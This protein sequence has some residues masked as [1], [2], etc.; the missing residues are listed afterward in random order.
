M[1]D[2]QFVEQAN[3]EY[4]QLTQARVPLEDAAEAFASKDSSG[5]IPIVLVPKYTNRIRNDVVVTAV[6]ILIGGITIGYLLDNAVIISLAVFLG[7]VTALLGA[8]RSFI[9]RVPEGV[10]GLLAKG[11]RYYKTIGAGT[12]FIPP[13]IP[14]SHLVTRRE[15]PFDIPVV[16][17]PTEDNVR[18]NLDILLTF[19]ISDPY[20]FVFSISADDFDQ[21]F[22][23][24][25]QD[26]LRKMLRKIRSDEITDVGHEHMVA[27]REELAEE[28]TP[29]GIEITK[30][31]ITYAQPPPEFIQLKESLKLVKLK[32]EEQ[33][34]KQILALRQQQ[35]AEVLAQQKVVA[36]VQRRRE[37]LKALSQQSEA[38][39]EVVRLEAEAEE[40][41]L[42]KLDDRLEKY[43]RAAQYELELKRL[44]I[45]SS[46][47]G[48]TRAML[49]V[50]SAD[51]IARAFMLKD[52]MGDA[53]AV[54]PPSGA[55]IAD[56]APASDTSDS[57]TADSDTDPVKTQKVSSK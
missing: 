19:R 30:I 20:N 52:I 45:A 10:N 33:K 51:D 15:I 54:A 2:E 57:A 11:G 44:D 8:Y 5:R 49:Q 21:V 32:Q 7:I 38:R 50:G 35:D 25:C 46:L 22:Q 56:D 36:S 18:A 43:P 17:S 12:H 13:W 55:L 40:L 39:R 48:N 28:I 42:E 31:S 53:L 47:A 6:V 26:A 3:L 4:G 41:R 1:A 29:Y 24:A 34:E 16:E 14:V 23:A 37:E 27:L 9:V